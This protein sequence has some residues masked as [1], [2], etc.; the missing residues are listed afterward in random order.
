MNGR[1]TTTLISA[2]VHFL[3]K[4]LRTLSGPSSNQPREVLASLL[5]QPY[6]PSKRRHM[7]PLK[8]ETENSKRTLASGAK[9]PPFFF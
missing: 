6:Y 7:V 8:T 5:C 2:L 4:L 3:T 9:S 1:V